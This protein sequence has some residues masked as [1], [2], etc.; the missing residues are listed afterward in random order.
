MVERRVFMSSVTELS[1]DDPR[2]AFRVNLLGRIQA[3]GYS[4]QQFGVSGLPLNM[5]WSFQSVARVM[6]RCVGAAV[7]GFALG[8]PSRTGIGFQTIGVERHYEGAVALTLGLPL[9][10]VMDSGLALEGVLAPE[11]GKIVTSL[12]AGIEDA[13]FATGF[14]GWLREIRARHDIFLG[15]C[16]KSTGLAA[17]IQQRLEALGAT[18]RNWAV[19]FRSGQ[20]I[21][22]EVQAARDSCSAGVFLFSEDDKYGNAKGR[23]APRDNVVFELGYFMS[24]KGPDR[25]LIVR[26]GNA[27][28]PADLGGTIYVPLEKGKDVGSIEERLADFVAHAL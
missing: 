17:A 24:A 14:E 4:P 8:R 3:S 1:P 22:A 23:A 13:P 6:E 21:L 7:L 28:I 9:L 16:S 12:P 5:P 18:V 10:L 15:Y 26:V 25:C 2:E 20:S 11:S 19:D 27:K